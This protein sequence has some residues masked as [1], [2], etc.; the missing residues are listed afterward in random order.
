MVGLSNWQ[1]DA[2]KMN[3]FVHASRPSLHLQDL[4]DTGR[5]LKNA[6]N[7]HTDVLL[8]DRLA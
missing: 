3:R 7:R 4:K 8:L 6:I 1:L 2:A 5:S